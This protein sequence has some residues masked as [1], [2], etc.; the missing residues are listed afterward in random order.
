M[1]NLLYC[2]RIINTNCSHTRLEVPP[3]IDEVSLITFSWFIINA[4]KSVRTVFPLIFQYIRSPNSNPASMMLNK[5]RFSMTGTDSHRKCEFVQIKTRR[6]L[7][8]SGKV[9]EVIH[10]RFKHPRMFWLIEAN[11]S[12][13]YYFVSRKYF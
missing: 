10:K 13:L 3:F 4:R 5:P 8:V 9:M 2:I 1:V 12:I 11:F 6:I 7:H